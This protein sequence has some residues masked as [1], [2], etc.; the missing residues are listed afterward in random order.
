MGTRTTLI[1]SNIPEVRWASDVDAQLRWY[2]LYTCANHEKKAAKEIFR[3]GL[4]SFL[5][6]Y[7]TT[8]R[9]SDRRVQIE[10]PLFPGYVFVHL[11]LCDRLKALQV[12]GVVRLVGFSGL[13]AALPDEQIDTLRAGLDEVRA[14]PHPLLTAG[15]RVRIKRGPL[16]GMQGILLRRKGKFR[17]V[18][19]ISVIQRA[20]AVDVDIVDVEPEG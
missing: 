20:I 15:K 14:Q 13:P 17:L 16:A 2:A 12:P 9:W 1:Q 7:K 5:P 6:V 4:D 3:R 11:A 19:S 10:M 8:R 18:I